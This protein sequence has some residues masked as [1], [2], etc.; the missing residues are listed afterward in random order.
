MKKLSI[1]VIAL[2]AVAVV[3]CKEKKKEEIIEPLEEVIEFQEPKADA[4]SSEIVLGVSN[5][6]TK[7]LLTEADLNTMSATDR[8]FKLY[9]T[10]LNGDGKKEIFVNLTGSYFCGSGGCT[11]LLLDST[12]KLITKF[13]VMQGSIFVEPT[14]END[15]KVLTVKSEGEWKSLVYADG[16][17]PSNPSIVEKAKYDAPS[18]QAVVVF[19]EA[20][21][22]DVYEF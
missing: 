20:Q 10:D 11:V 15:W 18:G 21:Q 22:L 4:V 3:S 9:T 2:L 13:T 7:K 5:F 16:T 19:D 14:T 6:L 12:Y 17:Y 8:Q 1:A